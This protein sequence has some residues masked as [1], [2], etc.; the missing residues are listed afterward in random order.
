VIRLWP[1]IAF[2]IKHGPVKVLKRNTAITEFRR[3]MKPSDGHGKS[4]CAILRLDV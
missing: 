2:D 1:A 3:E 4:Q